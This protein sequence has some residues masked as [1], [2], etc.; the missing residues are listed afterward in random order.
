MEVGPP[1]PALTLMGLLGS[2]GF[3]GWIMTKGG[4]PGGAVALTGLVT[5]LMLFGLSASPTSFE[6][7][8]LDKIM[9]IAV[10]SL[11]TIAASELLLPQL[12]SP[13][14]AA[15]VGGLA[16]P[17]TVAADQR[18]MTERSRSSCSHSSQVHLLASW[19]CR[20]PSPLR[21]F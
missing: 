12:K 15:T 10:L 5:F 16:D 1:L 7:P 17:F 19:W 13:G 3:A 9:D 2:L 4:R 21:H 18:H 6:V 8:V 20:S 14:P 11:Y